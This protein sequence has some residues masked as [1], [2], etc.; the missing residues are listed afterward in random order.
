MTLLMQFRFESGA[1]SRRRSAN[2]TH[3]DA[4]RPT[5]FDESWS[6]HAAGSGEYGLIALQE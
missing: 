1:L 3:L 5:W 2:P 6:R 4:S